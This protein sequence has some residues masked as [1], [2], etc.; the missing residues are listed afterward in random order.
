MAGRSAPLSEQVRRAIRECGLTQYRISKAAGIDRSTLHRFM[1]G[2]RG[3]P[4]KT[5]DRLAEV[6]DLRV[7]VG[8]NAVKE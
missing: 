5:L 7:S 4:M 1:T 6:L 2:E 8:P 3:L